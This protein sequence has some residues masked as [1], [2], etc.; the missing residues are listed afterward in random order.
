[1]YADQTRTF[2]STVV[3]VNPVQCHPASLNSKH[4]Y[5]QSPTTSN[6]GKPFVCFYCRKKVHIRKIG[7]LRL[8]HLREEV[9]QAATPK[10]GLVPRVR[11]IV[12]DVSGLPPTI[13]AQVENLCLPVLLDSGSGG[14]LIFI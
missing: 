1:M 9:T 2:R 10:P 6:P 7:F 4:S 12:G 11:K 5:T 8:A 3:N 13:E 14:S